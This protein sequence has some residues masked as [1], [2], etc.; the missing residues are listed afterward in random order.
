MIIRRWEVVVVC[1]KTGA[2]IYASERKHLTR[3][4]AKR[5]RDLLALHAVEQ[6]TRSRIRIRRRARLAGSPE[7]GSNDA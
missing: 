1:P 2:V 3:R 6:G 5:H 7:E 4:A